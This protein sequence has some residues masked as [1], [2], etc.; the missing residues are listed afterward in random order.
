[1]GSIVKTVPQCRHLNLPDVL[2]FTLPLQVGH[3]TMRGIFTPSSRDT[4]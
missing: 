2:S 3:F 1:M 4:K